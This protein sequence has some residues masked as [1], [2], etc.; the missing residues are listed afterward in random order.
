M[1]LGD[2]SYAKRMPI[3]M[4]EYINEGSQYH[5]IINRIEARCKIRY[6]FKQRQAECKGALLSTRN[7]GKVLHKV[8]KSFGNELSESLSI[9]G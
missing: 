3:Y 9:L 5:P 1:S 7:M 2:E 4:L 6:C 8:L